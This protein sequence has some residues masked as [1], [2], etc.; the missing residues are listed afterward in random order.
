MKLAS[1]VRLF[2]DGRHC[3]LL[4]ANVSIC[5]SAV[6]LCCLAGSHVNW[7]LGSQSAVN[8][9]EITVVVSDANEAAYVGA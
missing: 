7:A 6:K 2:P 8:G 3:E 1:V 4:G 9:A 5:F